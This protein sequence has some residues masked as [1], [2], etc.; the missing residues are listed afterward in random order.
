MKKL[1]MLAAVASMAFGAWAEAGK[2]TWTLQINNITDDTSPN[3]FTAYLVDNATFD[4]L[5]YATA[6]NY[7]VLKDKESVLHKSLPSTA[8][9]G[10]SMSEEHTLTKGGFEDATDTQHGYYWHMSTD[11]TR[12]E[13]DMSRGA[14]I[15]LQYTV[16]GATQYQ[17][18]APEHTSPGSNTWT[19]NTTFNPTPDP[20][21]PPPAAPEPTSAMLML[22][23]VAGLALKRKN[24]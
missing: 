22:L 20:P 10:L 12:D 24:A 17:V 6:A 4:V 16:A 3:N 9:T 5:A 11:F 15:I 7:L 2:Y 1:L 21:V 14:S 19:F 23:G 13:I 18:I 8:P